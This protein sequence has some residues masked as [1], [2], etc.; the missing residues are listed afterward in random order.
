MKRF[1]FTGIFLIALLW[2]STMLGLPLKAEAAWYAIKAQVNLRQ[3]PGTRYNVL[4]RLDMNQSLHMVSRHGKWRKVETMSGR[5]GF[6][7]WDMISDLWIKVHKKQRKLHLMQGERVRASYD[8]SLSYNPLGDKVKQGDAATPEGRFYLCEMIKQPK[9]AKYGARSMRLSYPNIEDARR[10]LEAGLIKYRTYLSIVRAIKHG[11]M[12]RQNTPLG[13]SLRIHGGGNQADWT[14]G[15]VGMADED[16]KRLW[17]KVR[18]GTRVEVY[19]SVGQDASLNRSGHL[20]RKILAGAKSQLIKP[21]LYTKDATGLIKLKYP[22]GDIPPD[23]AVCTDVVI[24]ALR[25]AG[26]DLQALLHEDILSHPLRYQRSIKKPNYN[27]DH[28]RTRNL[29]IWL[30]HYAKELPRRYISDQK[31]SFKPG[32]LV[33]MDTGIR[34]GTI[35]D[36][37][38]IVDDS[39]KKPMVI[40]IWDLGQRTEPM[41][42]IG[43]A[44]PAVVGHFRLGHVFDYQ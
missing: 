22:M 7:R 11:R 32:D 29:Q 42:L 24:R 18:R 20:S 43:H 13:G 5:T 27:I 30:R 3:G 44:Y 25:L 21:A 33:I 28:R 12:P 8:I 6:V 4:Q 41:D 23:Q 37:I 35:Y 17:E 2:L 1:R 19:K 39:K 10:G 40:N 38:G 9:K 34:N 26:L 14:L 31:S 15:C 36:H 16:V